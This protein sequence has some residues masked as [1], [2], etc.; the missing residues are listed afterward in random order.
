MDAVPPDRGI[1]RV[2]PHDCLE[3]VRDSA[4]ID[5]CGGA[6]SQF[7]HL[8]APAGPEQVD[9]P[10]GQP[11]RCGQCVAGGQD[12][13]P[14]LVGVTQ[15]VDSFDL[16][17]DPHRQLPFSRDGDHRE[18]KV[19]ATVDVGGCHGE[20]RVR[21]VHREVLEDQRGVEKIGL[22]GRGHDGG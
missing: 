17:A 11:A 19:G 3:T 14:H 16:G 18:G 6:V 10:D 13:R 2:P 15:A 22:P 9:P 1:P 20:A 8:G 7:E 5:L 12:S 4:V 21:G